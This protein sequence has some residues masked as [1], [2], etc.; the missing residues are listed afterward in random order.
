MMRQDDPFQSSSFWL[1]IQRFDSVSNRDFRWVTPE[2]SDGVA[3]DD[4]YWAVQP[5]SQDKCAIAIG[6]RQ[7]ENRPWQMED[8]DSKAEVVCQKSYTGEI[9]QGFLWQPLQIASP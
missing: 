2:F 4:P 9:Q 3:V 1:A 5:N 8:C 7:M 6:N